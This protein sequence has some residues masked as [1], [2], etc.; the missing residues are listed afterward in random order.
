MRPFKIILTGFLLLIPLA[1]FGESGPSPERAKGISVYFSPESVVSEVN[2]PYIQRF[3][4]V[5]F[6][7]G[8]VEEA[9]QTARELLGKIQRYP[10]AVRENGVWLLLIYPDSYSPED[11][12]QLTKLARLLKENGFAYYKCRAGDLPKGWK[13]L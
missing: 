13:R 3:L 5:N 7:K 4:V 11:E 9:A 1:A 12:K 2:R 6:Q 8:I 10:P